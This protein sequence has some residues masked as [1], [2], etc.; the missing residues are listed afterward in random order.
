MNPELQDSLFEQ[1]PD[2]FKNLKWIECQDGWYDILS[3]LCYIINNRLDYKKRINEPLD[4]F[5][6][7]QIKEKFGGLRAYSDGAD[8]FIL[9]A[10][11]M[12]E[13]MSYVTC[14]VTGE[15]GKPR[16]QKISEDGTISF[17]WIRTLCDDEAK[18]EG[19]I[20]H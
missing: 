9:G 16:K 12:A 19:Y 11:A 5:Y 14:E 13:S 2:Q 6:W 8:D 10:I 20:L 3:R 7:S 17:G 1:Y 15:K 18:K 4:F